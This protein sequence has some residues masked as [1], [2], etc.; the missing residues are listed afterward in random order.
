MKQPYIL[1]K[2]E[3]N[4]I[5]SIDWHEG[6]LISVSFKDGDGHFHTAFQSSPLYSPGRHSGIL[7]LDLKRLVKNE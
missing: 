5:T 4:K 2:G 7:H 1:Y 6:K 3:K